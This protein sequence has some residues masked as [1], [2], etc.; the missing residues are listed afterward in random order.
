MRDTMHSIRNP[1]II[2][3]ADLNDTMTAAQKAQYQ[4][5]VITAHFTTK[6]E[7]FF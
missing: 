5:T 7:T 4:F 6:K 2:L 1:E 3:S